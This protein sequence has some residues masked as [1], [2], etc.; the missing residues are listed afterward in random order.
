MPV[1]AWKRYLTAWSRYHR[2][3]GFGVHSPYAYNF[4][5]HV[6]RQPLP[7]YAYQDIRQLHDTI[8]SGMTRSQCRAMG[9][10]GER[11]ALLLFRVTNFF[12]PRHILQV[13]AATGIESVTMLAVNHLSRLYLYDPRLEQNAIAVKVLHTQLDRVAC[14]DDADVAVET[15]LASG[16]HPVL[17]LF[18]EPSDE[19]VLRRLLDAHG[20]IV[21]RH[22]NR[23]A[24]MQHLFEVCCRYMTMGQTYSNGKI[25][26]L[27]PDPKLQREDFVLW[28]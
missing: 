1:M 11:E 21:L 14:Y 15:L 17:A 8:R 3:S 5:R 28:L 22:L 27:N 4:V 26:I 13:G 12:N 18:N 25:A 16:E 24:A 19:S 6:W 7:Y 9:L 23:D 2:S 10:I 20:I